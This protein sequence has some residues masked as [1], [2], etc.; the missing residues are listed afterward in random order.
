M[1]EDERRRVIDALYR[2]TWA[3]DGPGVE[4][5]EV[6]TRV[7]GDAGLDGADLVRRASLPETKERLKK[8]TSDAIAAGVFGVPTMRV[9]GALFWGCDSLPH[10]TRFLQ[11]DDPVKKD[12]PARWVKVRP[13]V[14]RTRT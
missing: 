11:G 6:V 7:L 1:A 3:G 2:A 13:S 10:L 14:T 5:A 4:A 12:D 9:D 8:Q